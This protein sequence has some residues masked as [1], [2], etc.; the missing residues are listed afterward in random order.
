[1]D[2]PNTDMVACVGIQDFDIITGCTGCAN[3]LVGLADREFG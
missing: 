1:M 3:T 2:Q